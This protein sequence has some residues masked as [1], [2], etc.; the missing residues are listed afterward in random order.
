MKIDRLVFD[1]C[2]VHGITVDLKIIDSSVVIENL[3]FESAYYKG[4]KLTR[5]IDIND[6]FGTRGIGPESTGRGQILLRLQ[7]YFSLQFEFEQKEALQKV[8]EDFQKTTRYA[9]VYFPQ[10]FKK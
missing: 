3:N 4:E 2:E 5:P 6:N 1:D 8:V 7:E 10:N 9:V